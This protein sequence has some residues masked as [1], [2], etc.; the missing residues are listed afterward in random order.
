MGKEGMVTVLPWKS[1]EIS[2][3][4]CFVQEETEVQRG[5]VTCLRSPYTR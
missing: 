2:S 4:P 1:L 5:E 3:S